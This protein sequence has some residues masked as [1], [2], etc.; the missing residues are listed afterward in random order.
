M[1]WALVLLLV[2]GSAWAQPADDW[3]PPP[4]APRTSVPTPGA[5]TPTATDAAPALLGGGDRSLLQKKVVGWVDSRT[6]GGYASVAHLLPADDTPHLSNL[7]EANLLLTLDWGD[8]ARVVGD[9]SWVWGRGAYFYADDGSAGR[10]R[11]ASHDVP[12]AQSGTFVSE[13]YGLFRFGEHWNLTLGKKRVVWGTGLAWNPTDL[14]NPPK[15]PTDPTQQ[16]TGSWL[17]R[18]E[19]QYERVSFS[20]VG[21]AKATA[22]LGGMPSRWLWNPADDT[23]EYVVGAR[24]YALVADTDLSLFG[25]FGNRFNDVFED[26][27]RLGAAFSR[28]VGD[29]FE[30][31]GEALLQRGSSRLYLDRSCTADLA[32]AAGC[33]AAGKDVAAHSRLDDERLRAKTLVGLRYQFG[34]AAS[35]SVEY[36]YNQEG[37]DAGEFSA[38]AGAM[39]LRKSAA[40]AGLTL[41]AGALPG[42]PGATSTDQGGT[43]QK[44]AFEPLRRHYLFVTYLHPQL[45]DDFTITTVLLLGLEDGSG[46]LAPQLTWSARQWLN[47]SVG[48]FVTLPGLPGLGVTTRYGEVREFQ[49]QP[50]VW[51]AF[52]AAR[53][54]F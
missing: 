17:A 45:A 12:A 13:L 51:R 41:P 42:M 40:Q 5:A 21:A 28:V 18:V 9:L 11:I 38:F 46:Q 31:H 14:L 47:L 15:D 32:A 19:G 35:V 44:F 36:L 29:S 30:V 4:L 22:Q 25:F 49:L 23:P 6:T 39:A 54:F 10:L 37:Y 34:A 8:V 26:K 1:R 27:P 52:F 50:S 16:R 48:A 53:A 20:L 24:V 43:P 2:S 3:E 7:T 33:V